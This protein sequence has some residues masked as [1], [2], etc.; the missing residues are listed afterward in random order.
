M[1]QIMP[2]V[3]AWE[4]PITH[5]L[6]P[7][8]QEKEYR[9]HVRRKR[10]EIV[11]SNKEEAKKANHRNMLAEM[12]DSITSAAQLEIWIFEN[13][14]MLYK[15]NKTFSSDR[16]SKDFKLKSI[17]VTIDYNAKASNSH[18]APLGER[19][20][21]C[22]RDPDRPTYY[23]GLTGYLEINYEGH[24]GGFLTS[25]FNNTGIN[26]GSG[27]GGGGRTRNQ[28]TLY[29]KDWTGFARVI[30][31]QL[32]EHEKERVVAKLADRSTRPFKYQQD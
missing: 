6:F 23:P 17:H 18:C 2:K 26:T 13:F 29:L 14:R 15:R 11:R 19:D 7:L 31:E 20:N 12:R 8:T 27:G 25:I 22:G 30:E 9:K 21:W 24:Y 10:A 5:K 1:E 28:V 4:C 32:V 16:L 3:Q